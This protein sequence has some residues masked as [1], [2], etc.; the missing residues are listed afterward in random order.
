M[1]KLPAQLIVNHVEELYQQ[2]KLLLASGE[3]VVLDISDIEKADTAGLQLLCTIQ[4][5]LIETGQ[6]ITW[7]G[8]SIPLT[9][10]AKMIGV[11]DFLQL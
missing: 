10:T 5:N 7:S 1:F 8:S 11:N 3:D 9:D 4:K 6:K 2:L